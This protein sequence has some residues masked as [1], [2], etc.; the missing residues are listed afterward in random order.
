MRMTA[1][2]LALL[3]VSAAMLPAQQPQP[4]ARAFLKQYCFG[5]HTQQMKQRGS[6]PVALDT[7][8]SANVAADAKTWEMVV[9]KMRAG[10]MPPAGMPRPEKVAHDSFLSWLEGELDR[11]ARANPNPGRT[12]PVHRLNVPG[13]FHRID[14]TRDD[15][16]Y[17]KHDAAERA[18]YSG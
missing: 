5:C 17:P 7:L 4:D 15:P 1:P 8:D 3:L 9:R 14:C 2:F 18:R 13:A 16:E 12:E 6:V 11:A 10:L